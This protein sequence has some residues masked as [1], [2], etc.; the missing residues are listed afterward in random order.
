M[1][2]LGQQSPQR[3]PGDRRAAERLW[4]SLD[5]MMTVHAGASTWDE[6]DASVV[7]LSQ[8][9]L[10]VR[11][12]RVPPRGSQVQLRFDWQ[13]YGVCIGYGSIV[14]VSD[15]GGFAARFDRVNWAMQDFLALFAVLGASQREQLI[16]QLERAQLTVE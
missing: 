10:L 16:A 11:C 2:P 7:D 4:V 6:A 12:D 14:R 13:G 15:Y 3:E 1:V 8:S 5:V 9:G